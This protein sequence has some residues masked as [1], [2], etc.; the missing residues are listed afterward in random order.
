MSLEEL[1][2]VYLL[3]KTIVSKQIPLFCVKYEIESC[4]NC[5]NLSGYP[6]WIY[7]SDEKRIFSFSLPC[8]RKAINFPNNLHVW[9]LIFF[10][11][12]I[13]FWID[14]V[15]LQFRTTLHNFIGTV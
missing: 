3:F 4:C 10:G 6:L 15:K 13:K 9:L 14:D 7:D 8:K 2:I 1:A 12:G 11:N 5:I